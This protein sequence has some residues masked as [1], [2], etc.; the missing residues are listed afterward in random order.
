[1]LLK[2]SG[3]YEMQIKPRKSCFRKLTGAFGESS[4]AGGFQALALLSF[5]MRGRMKRGDF[6]CTESENL[7]LNT[8]APAQYVDGTPEHLNAREESRLRL[9][10]S[11]E[12][13]LPH[14]LWPSEGGG[15]TDRAK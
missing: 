1:M 15:S 6:S 3:Y 5:S 11:A 9:R 2:Q 12:T 4:E 8:I 10:H 14:Q 13:L 7:A